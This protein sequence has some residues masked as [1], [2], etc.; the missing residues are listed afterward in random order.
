MNPF[1][2]VNPITA[3]EIIAAWWMVLGLLGLFLES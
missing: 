1:E 2:A 3:I